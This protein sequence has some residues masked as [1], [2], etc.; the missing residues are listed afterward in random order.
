MQIEW[1]SKSITTVID[2]VKRPA[3]VLTLSYLAVDWELTDS[4]WKYLWRY[5]KPWFVNPLSRK[6]LR[7][8]VQIPG[9][10]FLSSHIYAAPDGFAGYY[11]FFL[12]ERCW[13]SRGERMINEENWASDKLV[14]SVDVCNKK[15]TKVTSA[16]GTWLVM[17]VSHDLIVAQF[18]TP[19]TPPQ[20]VSGP[21][22]ILWIYE[23]HY[24]MLC[25]WWVCCQRMRPHPFPGQLFVSQL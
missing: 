18:S 19:A 3:G 20:L 12:P 11:S 15:V 17:D 23:V 21:L 16:G 8:R 6:T 14:T 9:V 7:N 10:D 5:I 4:L 1:S 25:S 2:I 22:V 13:D 24:D